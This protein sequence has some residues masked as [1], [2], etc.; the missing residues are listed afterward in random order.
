[1]TTSTVAGDSHQAMAEL[2]GPVAA[3]AARRS[4]GG[5]GSMRQRARR[6]ATRTW[7]A[8][9]DEP[10]LIAVLVSSFVA[11][12]L[13][14]DRNSY[15]YDEFLSVLV[16][17]GWHDSPFGAVAALG[18]DSVHPPLYQFI[19]YF[20]VEWFGEGE[21]ATRSLSNLYITLA[22]L[23]LYLLVREAFSRRL[24]LLSAITFALMY[25]PMYYALEARSYAQTMFLATLS[26]YTLLR[27]MRAG[28]ARGWW[29]ALRSPTALVFMAAGTALLLTHYF[30]AFFWSA[31]GIMVG[32]YVLRERPPRSWLT[33][34][35]AVAALYAVQA[36]VFAVVW[37]GTLLAHFR[38]KSDGFAVEGNGVRSPFD[39]LAQV[40]S[41]NIDAPRVVWVAAA[42]V[43]TVMVLRTVHT[44][45]D[46]GPDAR[47]PAWAT[48]YLLA[49]L[50]LPFFMTTLAF[51]ITGVARYIPR[52]WLAAM[53]ALAPLLVLAIRE[54]TRLG[55]L[56]LE[57]LG[58]QRRGG[59]W[60]QSRWLGI[61]TAAAVVGF[62][63]PGTVAAATESKGEYREV[64]R[65]A[66]DV[67]QAD[68]DHEYIV[69]EAVRHPEPFADYYL[70][71]FGDG[72]AVDGVL[73]R[74][75]VYSGEYRILTTYEPAIAEHDYLVLLFT[76][77]RLHYFTEVIGVLEERYAVWLRQINGGRGLIIFDVRAHSGISVDAG[78][79]PTTPEEAGPAG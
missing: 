74:D 42:A 33:G 60:P 8:L 72:I 31:Q 3:G 69:I 62:V 57:R 52:Y 53:P 67:I 41:P 45:M 34:L 55:R 2:D 49:W 10:L 39:L 11:R 65:Q 19:L 79:P 9:G 28:P 56:G 7:A 66:V 1:M 71:Q 20:W 27:L 25:S 13:I 36:G 15:W 70:E 47:Q 35:G 38:K 76:H 29:P 43:A 14:A 18:S 61:A 24:G 40:I 16:Y 54:A 30:N 46:G 77:V 21:R 51:E 4:G 59:S 26:S 23:F 17:A 64:V 6:L 37:G 63:L 78:D 75:E 44:L 73:W 58:A 12:L 68:P 50:I 48:S 32:L 5:E 22:T